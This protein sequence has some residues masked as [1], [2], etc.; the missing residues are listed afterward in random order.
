M[1]LILETSNF[2]VESHSQPH[3]SRENGGHIVIRP[4]ENF[5]HR[6]EMPSA[7]AEELMK[8]TMLT[9]EATMLA[10]KRLG[11]DVV[12]INYQ[13][14]GNWAYKNNPANPKLH[15]HLYV[16]TSDE[17]HPTN[18]PSFQPFPEALVFPPRESGYYDNFK[19]LSPKDCSAIKEDVE[20]LL[21]IAKYKG[22]VVL[23]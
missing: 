9:G 18:H 12:R 6:F 21:T 7:I 16:R 20:K 2:I 22:I 15:V 11:L 1:P 4:K 19:P 3:H 14:N 5:V 10:L 23:D 17:K 13:D 8:L